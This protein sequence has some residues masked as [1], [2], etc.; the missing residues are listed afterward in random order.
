[1]LGQ[2]EFRLL[3]FGTSLAQLAFGMMQVVQG[4][5]A[6]DL[7]GKNSAVGFVSLGRITSYN[8][9]YTKLLRIYAAS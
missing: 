6:F 1:M 2:R 9:C 3:F 5:V 8:V 4:V 7:T